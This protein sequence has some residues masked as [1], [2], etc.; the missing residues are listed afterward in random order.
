MSISVYSELR[1]CWFCKGSAEA[2]VYVLMYSTWMRPSLPFVILNTPCRCD[3][4]PNLSCLSGFC[5][6]H[7]SVTWA[8]Q[9]DLYF[10]DLVP[11]GSRVVQLSRRMLFLF[12]HLFSRILWFRRNML[13]KIC[14]PVT[15]T[16][17]F[18][19]LSLSWSFSVLFNGNH[20]HISSWLFQVGGNWRVKLR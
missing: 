15:C 14:K 11:Y 7:Q 18:D 19:F 20:R 5:C 16:S 13:S 12:S 9:V 6:R 2:A 1:V 4:R 8:V 17:I 3:M 10:I